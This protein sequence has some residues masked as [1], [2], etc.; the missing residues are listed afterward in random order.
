MIL[1]ALL[2][3]AG[4]GAVA[5]TLAGLAAPL[6]WPWEQF[7]HFPAQ[8]A[9]VLG[10]AALLLGLSQRYTWAMA[11]AVFAVIN[12]G[13]LVPYLNGTTVR[14]AP[15]AGT[16]LRLLTLNVLTENRQY[17]R[18]LELIR[19]RRPDLVLLPEV[20]SPWLE[21]LQGLG[22]DYPYHIAVPEPPRFGIALFSR[23]PMEAKVVVPQGGTPT[24]VAQ[25]AVGQGILTV[26][27]AHPLPPDHRSF[28][29]RRNRQLR[30]LAELARSGAQP[31][32]LAGDLNI[33]PW[34]PVFQ[35]LLAQGGLYDSGLGRGLAPTWPADR[36]W[37][38]IP[39]D[40]VLLGDGIGVA[41]RRVGPDVG[42]DHFPVMVDLVLT[43]L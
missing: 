41:A 12:L 30:Y 16:E 13:Q 43:E 36:P 31:V 15:Q 40:H 39:I 22:S 3:L 19:Q 6:G 38:W 24:I 27:G 4:L 32:V 10:L 37:F 35:E 25:V 11:F 9:V 33:T 26:I 1:N 29:R 28:Q 21:A 23:L 5:T 8:Y 34:S 18:V 20:D 14:A 42:S 7:S 2:I 17:P